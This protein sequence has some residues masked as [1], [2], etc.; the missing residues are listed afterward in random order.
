MT[1]VTQGGSHLLVHRYRSFTRDIVEL[2][3]AG[4]PYSTVNVPGTG[5]LGFLYVL[6]YRK[7]AETLAWVN[8]STGTGRHI[9][10]ICA[11]LL[12]STPMAGHDLSDL[13]VTP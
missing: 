6:D 8:Y 13:S 7:G 10:N 4:I 9:C 3:V 11:T 12:S 2:P 5:I 1:S